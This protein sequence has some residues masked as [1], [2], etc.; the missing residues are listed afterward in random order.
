[1][2]LDP[3]TPDEIQLLIYALSAYETETGIDYPELTEKLRRIMEQERDDA[4]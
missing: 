3:L 4:A 2:P 1:M